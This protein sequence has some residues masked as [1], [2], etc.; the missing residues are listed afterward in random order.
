MIA[1]LIGLILVLFFVWSILPFDLPM[2]LNWGKYIV[3]FLQGGGPILALLI[4]II[5]FFIGVADIKD[6]MEEKKELKEEKK[7][8]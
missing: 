5:A 4:G 7:S 3:E 6:K 8:E 2:G 1:L